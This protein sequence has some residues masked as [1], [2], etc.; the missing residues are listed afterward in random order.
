MT[1]AVTRV[2]HACVLLD[3]DGELVLTDP[4]FRA[5]VGLG[6]T[7]PV[8][9]GVDELPP[10]TAV[11]VGHR[12]P[13]H[14]QPRALGRCRSAATTP[15]FVPG[16]RMARVARRAGLARAETLRWG[17]RRRAGGLEIRCLPGEHVTGM[18]TNAYVITSGTARVL[19][20][21][22][23]RHVVP[24]VPVDVAVLP[25]DGARLFGTRLVM[26][27]EQAVAAASRLGAVL[28][29]VHYASRARPPFLR[30]PT[31]PADLPGGL[32]AWPVGERAVV[33]AP[34]RRLSP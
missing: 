16:R 26:D 20:A 30:C 18:R 1:V 33:T 21:T 24:D 7:E 32:H 15:V 3:L 6:F 29:P 8:A 34:G 31:G 23:A 17:E 11:V 25:I 5:P 9:I 28:V 4:C 27:A 13:D 2:V 10:L 12:V 22:E 19:V 14:W